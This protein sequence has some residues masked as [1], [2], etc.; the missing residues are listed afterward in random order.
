V[1]T[2][3]ENLS[4]TRVKIV[5]EIPFDELQADLQEAYRTIASQVNVPGFRKGKVP[6]RIIDQRFG[7]G[8]V[9]SEVANAVIPRT[10]DQVI[11]ESDL[12]PLGQPKVEVTK[13][14]DGDLM[15]FVAEV[16]VRPEFELPPLE[17]IA[18]QVDAVEVDE[19][20]VAE[21]LLNLRKRFA[22]LTD[23]T[24]P[25]AEGDVVVVDVAATDP[26]GQPVE[27]FSAKGLNYEVGSGGAIEGFDEAVT[28]AEAGEERSF[29][30]IPA[31]GDFAGT[32]LTLAVTV[33]AVRERELPAADDDFA[34]LASQF[35]TMAELE[36]DLRRN[37]S[38]QRLFQQG[39]EARAKV[40]QAYL[41]L[42][43]I[44]L[45]DQL[46]A[47]QLEEHFADGH[48][49]EAH[50]AEH[51]AEL[52]ENLKA[53]LVLDKLAEEREVGVE[54]GELT[55]WL[56]TQASRYGMSPD[57]FANAL[58]SG[59][60]VQSAIGE[61]RRAKALSL[62]VEAATITDSNGEPVDLDAI[63]RELSGVVE[64]IVEE[65]IEEEL[66]DEI[67]EAIDEAADLIAEAVAEALEDAVEEAEA[68]A[69]VTGLEEAVE[70]AQAE[71]A[72]EAIDA[73]RRG[74]EAT[75]R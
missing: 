64:E 26:S 37:L 34:E 46:I 19:A 2:D 21:E 17:G 62:V 18:V 49:D 53:T 59:G 1:K 70:Q 31:E 5:V 10:Y 58:V 25:A 45:P 9:L 52:R 4:T 69:F 14:E 38:R 61:V 36:D 75:D 54:E 72:A 7:R 55:Q 16:D 24:R 13:L 8:T 73:E 39:S 60:Q 28:G 3:V 50:R 12:V 15:E 32:P 63:S 65:V 27:P 74:P 47:D 33:T 11:A 44:D 29:E 40:R 68:E 22:S 23:V 6:A 35:D 41:D 48:G 67:D 51:E 71:S 20:A 43:Q 30:H 66:E 42:I 57:Q 56:I